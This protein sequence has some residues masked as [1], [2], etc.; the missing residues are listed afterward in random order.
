MRAVSVGGALIAAALTSGSVLADQNKAPA[1]PLRILLTNDDGWNAPGITAVYDSLV[2]AGHDVIIVAPV[3][4][5]SGTGAR[6]TFG[7]P[8]V[9]KLEADRKYSVVGTPADATEVGL[10]VVF[11]ASPPDLV[12]SGTNSGQNI[13][14][15]TIHSG[16]VGAATTALNDGIPAI[17]VSTE[18][19]FTGTPATPF[20]ETAGFVVRLV[21]TM[22]DR[23]RGGRLLPVGVG[24]NVNYPIVEDGGAP[25]GVRE[26]VTGTG[27]IDI[28]Y[29]GA[30]PTAVGASSTY[31]IA[32]NPR[33]PE[34]VAN[35]DSTALAENYVSISP[36]E[37]DFDTL[38]ANDNIKQIINSLK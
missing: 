12:I 33:H 4:N 37:G 26:T 31:A 38:A 19:S 18:I 3:N 7:G 20:V 2:A 28:N 8:M 25:L 27:F 10:S 29:N 13:A 21:E 1:A 15:A 16:T 36:I 24:L 11:A 35:A 5:Q 32:V 23:A 34:T 22:Q 14:A 6:I 30:L 9:V 17:A